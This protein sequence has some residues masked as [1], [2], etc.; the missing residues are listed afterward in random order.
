[1]LRKS[2]ISVGRW[3]IKDVSC[4]ECGAI[5]QATRSGSLCRDCRYRLSE[6]ARHRRR[7]KNI[8]TRCRCGCG[9]PQQSGRYLPHHSPRANPQIPC[10]CGCGE[11][12][13]SGRQK[14]GHR[15]I[16]MCGCNCGTVISYA[17]SYAWGHFPPRPC[18]DCGVDVTSDNGGKKRCDECAETAERKRHTSPAHKARMHA[19]QVAN[20]PRLRAADHGLTIDEHQAL[21]DA[22]G[23]RCAICRRPGPI[24]GREASALTIDHWHGH[25]CAAN[26][27]HCGAC[28]R[29]LLCSVCNGAIGMLADDP[30]LLRAAAK[31][32]ET[33]V[34][35]PRIAKAQPKSKA[36]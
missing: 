22:Q 34:V 15:P 10:P 8:K 19:W 32:L 3:P 20:G 11:L 2:T 30:Q 5:H 29:G 13:I 23:G 14:R 35:P 12:T 6:N 24:S 18:M 1:M 26:G 28:V 36:A 25:G 17:A 31:Y 27:R 33:W 4:R 16:K 21:Y 7:A 9:L